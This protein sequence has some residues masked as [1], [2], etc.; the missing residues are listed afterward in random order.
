ME[1]YTHH[2]IAVVATDSAARRT[3]EFAA[4]IVYGR[5][6]VK[7]SVYRFPFSLS[8]DRLHDHI[9]YLYGKTGKCQQNLDKT[10]A[11]YER[12]IFTLW[13]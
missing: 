12:L 8:N 7:E 4:V 1:V 11:E 2:L 9:I 6:S 10:L 13:C 5:Y 3:A